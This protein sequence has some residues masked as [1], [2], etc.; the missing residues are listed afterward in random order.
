VEAAGDLP[1]ERLETGEKRSVGHFHGQ[2]LREARP[3]KTTILGE[4]KKIA[5]CESEIAAVV[6]MMLRGR[7]GMAVKW[8]VLRR[9]YPLGDRNGN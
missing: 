5:A 2:F 9:G 4:V 7:A 8:G 3:S 1:A 6:G